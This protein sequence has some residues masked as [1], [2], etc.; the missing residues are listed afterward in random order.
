MS[1]VDQRI[2]AFL[3]EFARDTRRSGEKALATLKREQLRRIPDNNL[4]EEVIISLYLL[5]LSCQ[6]Q[7]CYDYI[8]F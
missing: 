7:F 1:Y 5:T 4:K 2:E 3:K 6:C 8:F